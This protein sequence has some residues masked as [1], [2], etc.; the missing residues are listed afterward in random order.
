MMEDAM[1]RKYIIPLVI[2]VFLT[3]TACSEQGSGYGHDGH[4][5]NESTQETTI[6]AQLTETEAVSDEV[7]GV[8][9]ILVLA[10]EPF[11]EYLSAYR[12]DNYNI[13]HNVNL[14]L[15]T[16]DVTLTL[17]QK[18][19]Y[20]ELTAV[21][22]LT[23]QY[24]KSDDIWEL[25]SY[26]EGSYSTVLKT[27]NFIKEAGWYGKHTNSSTIGYFNNEFYYMI[28]I[29]DIDIENMYITLRY[30]IEFTNE[31]FENISQTTP[32]MLPL[33]QFFGTSYAVRIDVEGMNTPFDKCIKFRLDENGFYEDNW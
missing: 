14:D 9:E 19:L 3:L 20:T 28:Y 8:P 30:E 17:T 5:L 21:Y 12:P 18:S 22:T 24:Y 7:M 6:P 33:E 10:S 26:S 29:D 2:F 1:R 13:T 32:V 16:D 4:T 23:Y 27:E 11:N 31:N 15:H 25:I